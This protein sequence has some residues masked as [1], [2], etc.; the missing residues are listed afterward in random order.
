MCLVAVILGSV[1]FYLLLEFLLLLGS[2]TLGLC[3]SL[4]HLL[5]L[6]GQKLGKR[7]P[8]HLTCSC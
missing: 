1:I 6:A 2:T 3:Q 5:V 4:P 8:V 7:R